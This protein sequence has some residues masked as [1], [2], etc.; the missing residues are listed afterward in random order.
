MFQAGLSWPQ[1]LALAVAGSFVR[2]ERWTAKRLFRTDGG[3]VWV[4]G[5]PSRVVRATDFGRDELLALDW[6]NMGFDQGDC[7][8]HPGWTHLSI[9]ET[10]VVTNPQYGWDVGAAVGARTT[11][12][13]PFSVAR[14][15]RVWANTGY[16]GGAS[17]SLKGF[18]FLRKSSVPYGGGSTNADYTVA[19]GATIIAVGGIYGLAA[20]IVFAQEVNP[21]APLQ[22][23]IA[24]PFAAA[25][26]VQIAGTASDALL[27]NRVE[28]AL[29]ASFTLSAGATFTLAA[30]LR[31]PATQPVAALDL[32][33]DFTL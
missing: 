26:A 13:N 29:P 16:G 22:R 27:I 32:E 2:R 7:L 19:P 23:V 1:A 8:P 21:P 11:W 5:V 25:C 3:L 30:L 28:V 24:N 18:T 33:V 10:L 4:D 6:T 9:H 12:A 20:G 14:V 15:A 31:D 17:L